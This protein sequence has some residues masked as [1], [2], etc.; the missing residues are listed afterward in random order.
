[1]PRAKKFLQRFMLLASMP[2]SCERGVGQF[3]ERHREQAI[4][5]ERMILEWIRGHVRLV[6]IA[7]R[8]AI[9]IDD[10]D[11]VRPQILDVHLQRGGIHGHQHVHGVARRVDVASRR[12]ESG[13]R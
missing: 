5:V 8:E 7:L 10:Q 1:M 9:A 11:A 2:S 13:I 3:F 12:I 6:Q 4:A